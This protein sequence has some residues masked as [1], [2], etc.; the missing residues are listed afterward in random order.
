MSKSFLSQIIN[1]KPI[2]KRNQS[3]TRIKKN[4]LTSELRASKLSLSENNIKNNWNQNSRQ[5]FNKKMR[6]IIPYKFIKFNFL[7]DYINISKHL[8]PAYINR[9]RSDHSFSFSGESNIENN[10]NI[11]KNIINLST[12]ATCKKNPKV[13]LKKI[14]IKPFNSYEKININ[15]IKSEI[16]VNKII[17][18]LLNSE[19]KVNLKR[20][21]SH[22]KKQNRFPKEKMIDPIHYIKYNLQKDP[23]DFSLYKGINNIMN[24][25]GKTDRNKEYEI[26]LIK[27]ARDIN[28]KK[29]EVDH[30][31]IPNSENNLYKRKY[32]DMMK[33]TKHYES[34]HFNIND[35]LQNRIKKNSHLQ[36]IFDKTYKFHLD[37]KDGNKRYIFDERKIRTNKRQIDFETKYKEFISFDKR[38]NNILNLSKQTEKNVN[39]KSKEHEKMI[40]RINSIINSF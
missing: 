31:N 15:K 34:F 12:D 13:D 23:F 25:I 24:E 20:F 27:R 39:Q 30:L 19:N 9:I 5:I 4:L 32:E 40:N 28:N 21:N 10:K 29:I 2:N 14:Q 33:Q 38:I 36:N 37:K 35:Y 17:N 8:N 18:L 11:K 1:N 6:N 26:N 16:K 3:L 7:K 22:I